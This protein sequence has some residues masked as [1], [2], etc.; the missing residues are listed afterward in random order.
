MS[1][2]IRPWPEPVERIAA[3]LRAAGAEARIEQMRTETASAQDAA[4]AAGCTL[5]QI[6][7]SLVLVADGSGVV[8]ALVPGDRRADMRKIARVVGA[9]HVRIARPEEV[10]A[11]TGY[12]PGGVAPFALDG[13]R[14][15]LV[16]LSLW[17]YGTVW[18][19]AGSARHLAAVTTGELQRLTRADVADLCTAERQA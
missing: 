12:E 17:R 19:G 1:R 6:V 5:G 18:C 16:D 7:K 8:I 14:R 4:D 15:M 13:V 11:A 10:V 3:F 9:R 2:V